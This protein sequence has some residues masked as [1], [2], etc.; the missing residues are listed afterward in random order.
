MNICTS[1]DV[2]GHYLCKIHRVTI[3]KGLYY[4][5]CNDEIHYYH[6]NSTKVSTTVSCNGSRIGFQSKQFNP[7]E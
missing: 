3:D 1:V 2:C 6:N 7:V 5:W 4:L